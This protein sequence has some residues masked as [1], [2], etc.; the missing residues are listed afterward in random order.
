MVLGSYFTLFLFVLITLL[1][2]SIYA[3]NEH[4]V[5]NLL[6]LL[7][8]VVIIAI[9]P[10]VYVYA[11]SLT[12]PKFKKGVTRHYYLPLGLLV[13]NLLSF[14]YLYLQSDITSFEYIFCQS[15][16]EYANAAALFFV[17]PLS[18]V[19][20]IYKTLKLYNAHKKSVGQVFSFEEGVNLKWM[21]NFILGYVF[22]IFSIYFLYSFDITEIYIPIVFFISSYLVYIG[23]KGNR[24]QTIVFSS[25]TIDQEGEE[26]FFEA[27][28]SKT[29]A[30][31]DG[32]K[33]QEI[34]ERTTA[35]MEQEQPYLNAKLTIHELAKQVDTNSK[36]LSAILNNEFETNF[37]SYVNTYRI[38]QAKSLLAAPE[39]SNLTIEA[40]ANMAGF[41]SK[42]AFNSAFKNFGGQTPSAYKKA[43]LKH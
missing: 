31:I 1:A 37:V 21:L 17:F 26:L 30:L 32:D 38:N 10:T 15:V 36:Y 22:F 12:T 34:K 9:P 41:N 40:I 23:V 6:A 20:Y 8:F 4:P 18:N 27:R 39:N 11:S 33:M 43:I 42:S 14:G 5:L 19:F 29:T 7:F 3:D 35:V 24:Q 25:S 16:M 28:Q 13:I 2:H